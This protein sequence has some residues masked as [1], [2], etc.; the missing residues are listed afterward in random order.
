[1]NSKKI[2]KFVIMAVVILIPI[3]YSFFYLKSYWNPYGSLEDMKV[4]I[5][6]LD[7]GYNGENQGQ[8]IV[9]SLK[10]K[11]VVD[12]CDVSKS[13]AEDGLKNEKY[14]AIITI[15]EHF[16]KDLKSAGEI[17]KKVVQITYS[18]NQIFDLH[19]KLMLFCYI[20]KKNTF[21]L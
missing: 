14:Y 3:I 17:D 10:D 6:N 18:P 19:A 16:T 8:K 1:M 4:A 11:N 20:T 21:F 5:V 2:M 13:E 9:N 12:I 15:P 7:E